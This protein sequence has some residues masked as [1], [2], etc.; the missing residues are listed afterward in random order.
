MNSIRIYSFDPKSWFMGVIKS[1]DTSKGFGY[2][3]SNNYGIRVATYN[4][5][6]Y[7]NSDSFYDSSCISEGTVVVFQLEYVKNDKKRAIN[8]RPFS[9]TQKNDILLAL[10]YL[11][12]H[13]MVQVNGSMKNMLIMCQIK[14]Y[15]S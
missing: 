13:E 4:Q 5:D 15:N 3:A 11:E 6:F 2:I 14:G 1:F 12:S 7:I 8:V 10:N 9:N